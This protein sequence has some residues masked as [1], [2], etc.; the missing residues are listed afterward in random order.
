MTHISWLDNI[1]PPKGF[2][3]IGVDYGSEKLAIVFVAE[4]EHD[5]KP[6]TLSYKM[7]YEDFVKLA[8][9]IGPKV[10]ADKIERDG[11]HRAANLAG[12]KL[13]RRGWFD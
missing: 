9:D 7:D 5:G 1:R 6:V 13:K 8:L 2:A 10:I 12:Y 4:L 3:K 11:L